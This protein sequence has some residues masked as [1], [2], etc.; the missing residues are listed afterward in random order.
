MSVLERTA[1]VHATAPVT[2]VDTTGSPHAR[3]RPVGLR[4]VRLE[5]G[6][7]ERVTRRNREVT[8][9]RCTSS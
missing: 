3:L 6:L 2:V 7:L 9:A 8:I 5:G 4:R 1:G